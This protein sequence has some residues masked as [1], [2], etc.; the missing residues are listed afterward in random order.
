MYSHTCTFCTCTCR[1]TFYETQVYTLSTIIDANYQIWLK[2]EVTRSW[3]FLH[4][5]KM[6][7]ML[8]F[9]IS[10]S[11]T[12]YMYTIAKKKKINK[13]PNKPCFVYLQ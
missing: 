4:V 2:F 13:N 12:T 9:I 10:P 1:S 6:C 7:S 11:M 8:I 5:L 3:T